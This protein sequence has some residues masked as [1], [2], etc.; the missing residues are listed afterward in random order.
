MA[1]PLI[2]QE[3]YLLERYSS[4]DYFGEMRDAWAK[5]LDAAEEALRQ[6]VLQLPADYRS[7]HLSQQ[8]DLVWGERVLP[9][10]RSTLESLNE[11]YI[12]LSHGDLSAMGFGGN[13]QSAIKG[14]TSDY[15]TNWMP[16]EL[17]SKFWYWQAEAGTRAFNLAHSEF[18]GWNP[19]SL[20][21]RYDARARGPLNPP[22]LWPSYRLN[23]AITVSTGNPVVQSGIYLPACD[24]SCA[25]L[26]IKDYEAFS[27]T[28]GFNPKTQQSI[29]EVPTT[30][31]LVERVPEDVSASAS[32]A[33]H[34][35]SGT[36]LR[37]EA[38]QP[39]PREGFWFTPAQVGSRRYF[40]ASEAMPVAG[41]DYGATIW[42]WDQNQDPPKL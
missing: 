17:E 2:P 25:A 5:M 18:A 40:K 35:T 42:Q 33:A 12:L 14:Q 39:C 7:R 22:A 16:K 21:S 13:V 23:N 19:G 32:D 30:W 26:L 3:I 28:V 1:T 15:P 38:G 11:G 20:S 24:D 36:R 9:N 34:A 41:G 31:T 6:F 29:S 10:F 8:P 37:C 27:A 4:L